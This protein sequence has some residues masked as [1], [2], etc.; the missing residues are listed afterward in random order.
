MLCHY[1]QQSDIFIIYVLFYRIFL[2]VMKH[3]V[4][5]LLVVDTIFISMK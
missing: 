2:F 3:S 4:F 5:T 1:N